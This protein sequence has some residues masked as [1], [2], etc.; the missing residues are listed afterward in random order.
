MSCA[1]SLHADE[2]FKELSDERSRHVAEV[3]FKACAGRRADNR[4]IGRPPRLGEI[5][6][7]TGASDAEVAAVVEVFRREGRSFLMPPCDVP[8]N[9]EASIDISH[10]SLIRNWGRLK[11]WVKDEA[12]AARIYR[13]LADAA[14][15]YRVGE[16]GLLDD[17]T[18]RWVLRW[19]DKYSPN[20]AWGVRYHPEYDAAIA[21]LEESQAAREA[22][23][24]ERERKRQEEL[25]RERR[26]REQAE[27]HAADQARAARRLRTL[28]SALG[29]MFALAA[30]AFVAAIVLEKRAESARQSAEEIGRASCR[31]RV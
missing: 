21:Y 17:V 27:R 12:D 16:G 13:R 5:C 29:V 19:R 20:R 7:I 11:E 3:L 6:D 31:E 23:A 8:L 24:A 9:A 2:A 1:L 25:E 15:A 26:E 30:V 10:E 28:V 22:D 14:T 18:L 4:D